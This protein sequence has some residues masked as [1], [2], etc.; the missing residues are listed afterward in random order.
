MDKLK[1]LPEV[2]QLVNDRGLNLRSL[3]PEYILLPAYLCKE[4]KTQS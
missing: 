2:T 1:N 4:F 3:A